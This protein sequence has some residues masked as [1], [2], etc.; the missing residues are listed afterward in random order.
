MAEAAE[1][2]QPYEG[3]INKKEEEQDEQLEIR[4]RR[5]L[6]YT[7]DHVSLAANKNPSKELDVKNNR[8]IISINM[9]YLIILL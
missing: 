9:T 3:L 7:A 1:H 4:K 5:Y 6:H 8:E 2:R